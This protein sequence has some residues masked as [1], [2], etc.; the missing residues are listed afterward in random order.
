MS[1]FER[2]K[3]VISAVQ[4]KSSTITKYNGYVPAFTIED[5]QPKINIPE[6]DA[7]FSLNKYLESIDLPPSTVQ[8]VMNSNNPFGEAKNLFNGL[9]EKVECSD[10]CWR[11]AVRME[12]WIKVLSLSEAPPERILESTFM[13]LLLRLGWE[14]HWDTLKQRALNPDGLN[15]AFE[16]CRN[17]D[18]AR[19]LKVVDSDILSC[20]ALAHIRSGKKLTEIVNT[21]FTYLDMNTTHNGSA[22]GSFYNLYGKAQ[23]KGLIGKIIESAYIQNKFSLKKLFFSVEKFELVSND[24]FKY[25]FSK[26]RK[27]KE[28]YIPTVDM[29]E[30]IV[31][32]I[33]SLNS[34]FSEANSITRKIPLYSL[35]P[36]DIN[37][38]FGE[39]IPYEHNF[40]HFTYTPNTATGK[41]SKY[42]FTLW[43]NCQKG[44]VSFSG[45]IEYLSNNDIG[46]ISITIFD[47]KDTTQINIGIKDGQLRII[48]IEHSDKK[49][50][51]QTV[52]N[53][54][55][56]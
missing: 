41:L 56:K 20:F 9:K 53:Y 26:M 54:N 31:S 43:F 39:K 37:F 3:K 17:N 24:S 13:Y 38:F 1:L 12:R 25:N 10:M 4:E 47:I 46:K 42:P 16:A 28:I 15:Y 49:S 22:Q 29:K 51:M 45:R 35:S 34:F 50:Y 36:Q 7:I 32:D 44:N 2:L 40:C 48:K 33:L 23:I 18:Y 8:K 52:Y 27:N 14:C 11:E 6:Y 55:T 19:L 21:C 30:M 5:W